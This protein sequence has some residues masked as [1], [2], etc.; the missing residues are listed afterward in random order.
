MVG[1]PILL[2]LDDVF[3]WEESCQHFLIRLVA[4]EMQERDC[5]DLL[6]KVWTS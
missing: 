2:M 3:T 6:N 4:T 5:L 1:Y